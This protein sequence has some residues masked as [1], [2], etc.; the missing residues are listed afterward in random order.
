MRNKLFLAVLTLAM[1]L[2]SIPVMAQGRRRSV[3]HPSPPPVEVVAT[4]TVVPHVQPDGS[5]LYRAGYSIS[6]GVPEKATMSAYA[7]SPRGEK[8]LLNEI[9][10]TEENA[11]RGWSAWF[12]SAFDPAGAPLPS[13][14]KAGEVGSFELDVTGGGT[15]ATFS[16]DVRV[17]DPKNVVGPLK[18]A[19]VASDR[20]ISIE[21]DFTAPPTAAID[22]RVS[23]VIGTG[24]YVVQPPAGITGLRALSV[25]TSTK[26]VKCSTQPVNLF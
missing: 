13:T 20:M 12:F 16:H 11:G 18:S 5:I 9:T 22:G 17:G 15:N 26:P 19:T 21:G 6:S 1:T 3:A 24:V 25:C 7:I 8:Q 10:V 4:L 2:V 23:D 14:W